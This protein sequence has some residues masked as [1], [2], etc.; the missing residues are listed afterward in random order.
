[1]HTSEF[2][3]LS[4]FVSLKKICFFLEVS[5]IK[6]VVRATKLS[7]FSICAA[8]EDELR[9]NPLPSSHSCFFFQVNF[10]VGHS[11]MT[12]LHAQNM[13]LT[14]IIW[15]ASVSWG[16]LHNTRKT[17]KTSSFCFLFFFFPP[18][19]FVLHTRRK[20]KSRPCG[21]LILRYKRGFFFNP[22]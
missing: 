13:F 3:S 14:D 5:D 22:F 15:G 1:M 9:R 20:K 10:N 17:T 4:D 12:A 16:K 6:P 21:L 7:Y 19:L 8:C 11:S 2:H 18:I